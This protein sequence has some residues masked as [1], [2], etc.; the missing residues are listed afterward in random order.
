M[1]PSKIS[2]QFG[3]L[4][5]EAREG[6]GLTQIQFARRSRIPQPQLSKLENGQ[7][8]PQFTTLRSLVKALG[9]ERAREFLLL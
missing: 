7:R 6:E 5:R 3:R 2:H 9:A 1:I 4:L 8:L